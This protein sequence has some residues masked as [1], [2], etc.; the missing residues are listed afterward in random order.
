MIFLQSLI[1][2]ISSSADSLGIGITY[3]LK[4]TKITKID[5]LILFIISII[6]TLISG[7]IGNTLKLILNNTILKIIGSIILISMGIFIII[8]TNN[9]EYSFDFDNSNDINYKEACA[10][11]IALSLD[12]LCIGIGGSIIGINIWLF[13]ILVSCLQY[14]FLSLGHLL[15]AKLSN[16]KFIPQSMWS[17]ISGILLILIGIFKF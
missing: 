4:K 14:I 6:I 15:G 7:L 3:G 13:S 12:S 1:L 17:K 10:L 9:K 11:G 2:A 16:L 5:K 8:Q